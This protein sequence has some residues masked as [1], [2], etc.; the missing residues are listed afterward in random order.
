MVLFF[1]FQIRF[2]GLERNLVLAR[3]DYVREAMGLLRTEDPFDGVLELAV[4][5][6]IRPIHGILPGLCVD[7][8]ERARVVLRE[9]RRRRY[10]QRN[11]PRNDLGLPLV[12]TCSDYE[13]MDITPTWDGPQN[14]VSDNME[15]IHRRHCRRWRFAH[16][17]E[18]V[19]V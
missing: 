10:H 19:L 11:R 4:E 8:T 17:P 2:P 16:E 12:E 13:D 3:N 6:D 5:E 1:S 18:F 9:A 15:A 14:C 7:F